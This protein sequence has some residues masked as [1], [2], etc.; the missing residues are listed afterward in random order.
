MTRRDDRVFLVDML[1]HAR[2]AMELLEKHE[3]G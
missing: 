3:L 2:E 1:N